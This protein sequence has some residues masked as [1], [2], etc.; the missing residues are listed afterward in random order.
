MRLSLL[1][2]L[3]LGAAATFLAGGDLSEPVKVNLL[4]EGAGRTSPDEVRCISIQLPPEE[5]RIEFELVPKELAKGYLFFRTGGKVR[6]LDNLG[7]PVEEPVWNLSDKDANA[8]KGEIWVQGTEPGKSWIELAYAESKPGEGEG[9]PVASDRLDVQVAGIKTFFSGLWWFNGADPGSP[10]LPVSGKIVA[11]GYGDGVY[12]WTVGHAEFVR[13]GKGYSELKGY[14]LREVVARST[15]ASS[16][17]G[18]VT[19]SLSFKP[20]TVEEARAQGI[21]ITEED[22]TAADEDD[23][24]KETPP[25]PARRQYD[26]EKFFNNKFPMARI[27][28]EAERAERA[29]AICV[30]VIDEIS[31]AGPGEIEV[32]PNLFELHGKWDSVRF[33]GTLKKARIL[34]DDV[35]KGPV[36]EEPLEVVYLEHPNPAMWCGRSMFPLLK[37]HERAMF[38]LT[39][40][41]MPEGRLGLD[42]WMMA[43]RVADSK[44]PD[45][46]AGDSM[47]E[48]FQKE[49][50]HA[51]QKRLITDVAIVRDGYWAG[52]IVDEFSWA[53]ARN[54]K[55]RPLDK[56]CALGY[57]GRRGFEEA[58]DMLLEMFWDRALPEDMRTFALNWMRGSAHGSNLAGQATWEAFEDDEI[59]IKTKW[60]LL[61]RLAGSGDRKAVRT[62]WDLGQKEPA[63]I[64]RKPKYASE[65]EILKARWAVSNIFRGLNSREILG[66][67]PEMA[68]SQDAAA[69]SA[70]AGKVRDDLSKDDGLHPRMKRAKWSPIISV[71]MRLLESENLGV[72][73][74]AYAALCDIEFDVTRQV[75]VDGFYRNPELFRQ[76]WRLWWE[77]EGKAK[78]P[79]MESALDLFRKE[80]DAHPP[81]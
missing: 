24:P 37:E 13:D 65:D 2:V 40:K 39:T 17:A 20:M 58:D 18:D 14:N 12:H 60:E 53:I 76:G 30:G 67:I 4:I 35:L 5:Y 25:A 57:L 19:F 66:V 33:R 46:A 22:Q 9:R 78:C 26:G 59:T 29:E 50:I 1:A 45:L 11:Y 51:L 70:L 73:Y 81:D 49:V 31:N 64:D 80:L 69:Q 43:M 54:P 44:P 15:G 71:L 23:V 48:R 62:L 77:K 21:P 36:K 8:P 42:L 74:D 47:K 79:D 7:R 41:G 34:V 6:F 68:T 55:E 61:E 32:A 10:E 52:P 28:S 38:F 63:L 72:S 16:Y 27:P 75:A 56:A 3:L